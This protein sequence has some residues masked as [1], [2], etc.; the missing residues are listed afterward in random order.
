M[1]NNIVLTSLKLNVETSVAT[2]AAVKYNCF[3]NYNYVY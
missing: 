3:A 1:S 2:P